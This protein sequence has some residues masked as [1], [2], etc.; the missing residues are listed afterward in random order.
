MADFS[1]LSD[2][3]P[4]SK[5]CKALIPTLKCLFEQMEFNINENFTKFREEIL[6]ILTEKDV[7]ISELRSEVNTL[8]KTVSKLEDQLDD[9]DAY[10]RRDTLIFS[11]SSVPQCRDEENVSQLIRDIAKDKLKIIVPSDGI[12][13]SHRLGSKPATQRPDKRPIIV[14]FCQRSTK[15]DILAASRK[16]KLPDLFTNESLTPVRQSISY[17]LRK[18]KKEF[19]QI[20]SGTSTRDG[21]VF[22]WMKPPNPDA[23]PV[24]RPINNRQQLEEF[25]DRSL[26]KNLNYFVDEWT[27]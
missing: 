8:K 15:N 7:Q 11:G 25:C 1:A 20:I 16:L 17:V 18:A 9:N 10:E 23:R 27:H 19:P 6:G 21:R 12:S 4:T 22:V 5:D 26:K 3:Q 13:T 14:K 2:L 24:R